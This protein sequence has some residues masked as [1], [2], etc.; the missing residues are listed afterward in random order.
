VQEP[1]AVH[2]AGTIQLLYVCCLSE[3]LWRSCHHVKQTEP[4]KFWGPH[5][6]MVCVEDSCLQ[7][8]L[9]SYT[10]D[11]QPLIEILLISVEVVA[12]DLPS[13]PDCRH[14]VRRQQH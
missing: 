4:C 9:T 7:S 11:L 1:N 6:F 14:H 10:G 3:T 8:R 2:G 5:V 13:R 12:F